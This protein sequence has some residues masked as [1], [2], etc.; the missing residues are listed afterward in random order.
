MSST[1]VPVEK[2][3]ITCTGINDPATIP[4]NVTSSPP[5]VL[6]F[7]LVPEVVVPTYN[8][9]GHSPVPPPTYGMSVVS[10]GVTAAALP[11]CNF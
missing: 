11:A 6:T 10:L 1:S 5:A 4:V 8:T 2:T 7:R 3:L 9:H